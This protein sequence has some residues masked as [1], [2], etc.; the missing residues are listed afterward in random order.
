MIAFNL[1]ASRNGISRVFTSI[2]KLV[3]ITGD[4]YW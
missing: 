4:G 1:G 2:L 3:M